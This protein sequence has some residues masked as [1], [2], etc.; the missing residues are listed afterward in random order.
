MTVSTIVSFNTFIAALLLQSAAA[1]QTVSPD[2]H[3][4]QRLAIVRD[5]LP[6]SHSGLQ[7]I[8]E[9]D[10]KNPNHESLSSEQMHK[11]V[12]RAG[13]T[14]TIIEAYTPYDEAPR[15][16]GGYNPY[17][18]KS[19][20]GRYEA[21]PGKFIFDLEKEKKWYRQT[22]RIGNR[23]TSA[24]AYGLSFGE[25]DLTIDP[26]LKTGSAQDATFAPPSNRSVL[27]GQSGRFS[28]GSI[29]IYKVLETEGAENIPAPIIRAQNFEPSP[30]QL[31][32][33][34]GNLLL[35]TLS[36]IAA[37]LLFIAIIRTAR[38]QKPA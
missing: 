25:G 18:W 8:F 20:M 33:D 7:L 2:S 9:Y 26:S 6:S 10:S 15:V 13:P 30:P 1:I 21:N 35:E 4:T 29:R 23:S 14:V 17:K 3:E 28:I 32:P 36:I 31:V 22:K 37:F 38:K 11:A 16:I 5:W 24:K 12:D 34:E 27:T 19:W